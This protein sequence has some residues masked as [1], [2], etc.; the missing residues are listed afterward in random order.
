MNGTRCRALGAF[1]FAAAVLGGFP[2]KAAP[3]SV[4]EIANYTGADR[5]AILEA[6]ARKEGEVLLYTTGTQIEPILNRIRE[7]YPFFKLNVYRGDSSDVVRRI[8][9]EYKARRY[10]ADAIVLNA[11]G[12]GVM[13]DADVLQPFRTPE[14]AAYPANAK[15]PKRHWINAY[16]AYVSLGFNT[17]L[18]PV[19]QAPKTWDDLLDPKWN[20]RMALSGRSSTFAHWV[21]NLVLTKGEDFVMQ[22]GKQNLSVYEISGRALSNLVVSGEVALSPEIYDSHMANSSRQGASVSWRALGSVYAGAGAAAVANKAPHP[23]AAMLVLD[24]FLSKEGQEL[25]MEIG[26]ASARNDLNTGARPSQILYLEDRPNYTV[27]YEQWM[28]LGEKAFGPARKK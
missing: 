9:E 7:K 12:L 5:T 18:V 16:E 15:E 19:E 13:R 6:G 22:L 2:A 27:E 21:G 28:A 17:K 3:S 10:V 26:D 25:R 1:A 20:G 8:T 23:H 4:A 11:G 14:E 24:Y